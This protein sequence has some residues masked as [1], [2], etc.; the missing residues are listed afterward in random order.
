MQLRR[1]FF[2]TLPR[3]RRNQSQQLPEHA[4][5]QIYTW[6]TIPLITSLVA[7]VLIIIALSSGTGTQSQQQDLE[8]Y[9]IF[10][11]NVSALGRGLL[12]R[13]DSIEATALRRG[14]SGW[15]DT[16]G[17]SNMDDGQGGS[18]HKGDDRSWFDRSGDNKDDGHKDDGQGGGGEPNNARNDATRKL[19]I[20]KT[21]NEKA[22]DDVR[23]LV[24]RVNQIRSLRRTQSLRPTVLSA[25]SIDKDDL[26]ELAKHEGVYLTPQPTRRSRFEGDDYDLVN[27]IVARVSG[28]LDDGQYIFL[29]SNR[30]LYI[31]R[32][33]LGRR[34]SEDIRRRGVPI[35]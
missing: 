10:A 1:S 31:G 17:D 26:Y 15:L 11:V 27:G 24:E 22:S 21:E 12:A 4:L 29:G 35:Q 33:E 19:I 28:R 16:L 34:R 13:A 14:L 25:G 3:V 23:A 30:A 20:G 6:V 32:H 7:F 2:T 9:H 18:D 8:H 5:L